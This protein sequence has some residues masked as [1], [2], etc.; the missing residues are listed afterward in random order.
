[1]HYYIYETIMF[2]RVTYARRRLTRERFSVYLTF[3]SIL[4]RFIYTRVICYD[5]LALLCIF[6]SF[7]ILP[8]N[9]NNH[10]F[11]FLDRFK[12]G[13]LFVNRVLYLVQCQ[14][15]GL[16]CSNVVA[17]SPGQS[18]QCGCSL[19]FPGAAPSLGYPE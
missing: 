8:L 1:M 12:K 6:G 10:Q 19:E 11:V 4:L 14:A 2:G 17:H 3:V 7:I 5:K 13:F 15:V 9:F 16:H 18:W